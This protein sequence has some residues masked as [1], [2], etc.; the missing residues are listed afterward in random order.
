MYL[1]HLQP[2]QDLERGSPLLYGM[3]YSKGLANKH[4]TTRHCENHTKILH[5]W[6]QTVKNEG[7]GSTKEWTFPL[8]QHQQHLHW[9]T[10]WAVGFLVLRP[11]E[12]KT[13]Q[14]SE[15]ESQVDIERSAVGGPWPILSPG[16]GL[17]T[18]WDITGCLYQNHSRYCAN[19]MGNNKLK[20]RL[21]PGSCSLSEIIVASFPLL[22]NIS[23]SWDGLQNN[24]NRAARRQLQFLGVTQTKH[25]T[26]P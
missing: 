7:R 20:P 11:T 10:N 13:T 16:L 22:G 9:Q 5:S 24:Y 8:Q 23:A 1:A 4:F 25:L 19:C 12:G 18:V 17:A 14:V 21:V 6:N 2:Q 15:R 26:L 3:K